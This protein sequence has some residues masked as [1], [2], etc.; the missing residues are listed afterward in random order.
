MGHVHTLG[1]IH[2]ESTNNLLCKY[3]PYEVTEQL[4]YITRNMT[5]R[6][7]VIVSHHYL[8]NKPITIYV[9]P[10][11]GENTEEE[12]EI[13]RNAIKVRLPRYKNKIVVKSSKYRRAQPNCTAL[14]MWGSAFERCYY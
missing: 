1:K 13:V 14:F 9:I 5:T 12:A 2:F 8:E 7:L 4:K 10:D 3:I 11:H 6:V